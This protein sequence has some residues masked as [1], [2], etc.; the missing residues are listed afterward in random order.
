M[1]QL[2]DEKAGEQLDPEKVREAREEEMREI[3]R[4]VYVTVDVKECWDKTG[5]PPIGIR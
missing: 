5:K 1:E 4:R 2:A 3:E